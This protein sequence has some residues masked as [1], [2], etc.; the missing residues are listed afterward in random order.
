MKIEVIG[1]NGLNQF[2]KFFVETLTTEIFDENMNPV[3]ILDKVEYTPPEKDSELKSN[4][5]V[6]KIQFGLACNYSCEYC[7]QRF[8]PHS[9]SGKD[10]KVLM[11]KLRNLNGSDIEKIELWGGEPL[12]YYS[13]I[14][15]ALPLLKEF[16]PN[17]RFSMITNGSLL[18][19]EINDWIVENKIAI[20]ISHDGVGQHVRG[21]D[22]FEDEV[23]FAII[24]NLYDRLKPQELISVNCMINNKN[25]SRMANVTYFQNKFGSDI[26]I[27]EGS[28][29]DVYDEGAMQLSVMDEELASRYRW[30]SFREI[31]ARAVDA[32]TVTANRVNAYL[33][34]YEKSLK[35][36]DIRQKC[37]MS[38][39]DRIAI[40]LEGDVLTCQN[41][42]SV[43]T[44]SA[45]KSHLAGNIEDLSGVKLRAFTPLQERK[46]CSSCVVAPICKGSCLYLE[47]SYWEQSCNNAWSDCVPAF[48]VAFELITGYIPVEVKGR[49]DRQYLFKPN[50]TSAKKVIPIKEI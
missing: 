13:V 10:V 32:F 33:D 31:R 50:K 39:P 18:T 11:L 25:L 38:Q 6:L 2:K 23:Q 4:I 20:G 37:G 16:A 41:V 40:N 5:K 12:A 30:S 26:A 1:Q 49:A 24:K 42:S 17:A 43:S 22:P 27:G 46:D 8:V 29:V 35:F 14:K 44:N 48:A 45:G 15:E 21:P 36:E 9:K 7:S 28:F 47:G 34:A 3:N 19:L